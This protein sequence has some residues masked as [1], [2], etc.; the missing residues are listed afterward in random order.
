MFSIC[1]FQI[2]MILYLLYAMDINVHDLHKAP[3]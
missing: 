3:V 1:I 2:S